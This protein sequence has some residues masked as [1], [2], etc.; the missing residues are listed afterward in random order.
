MSDQ[1]VMERYALA[2]AEKNAQI[3]RLATA[4]DHLKSSTL[5]ERLAAIEH[6]RWSGWMRHLF[7]KCEDGYSDLSTAPLGTKIIPAWA[8]ERWTRQMNTPYADLTEAEKE[9]DRIEV[10]KTLD[11]I[12]A[13]SSE[14]VI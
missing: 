6:E 1:E 14:E 13:K 11:A 4:L 8:T 7:S 3:D 5:M 12:A 2:L 9:S 10:R